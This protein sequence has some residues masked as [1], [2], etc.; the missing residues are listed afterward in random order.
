[1]EVVDVAVGVGLPLDTLLAFS[2]CSSSQSSSNELSNATKTSS[3][4]AAAAAKLAEWRG[5]SF[6]A[7]SFFLGKTSSSSS[8]SSF[9]QVA[10]QIFGLGGE[11]TAATAREICPDRNRRR[12]RRLG[13]RLRLRPRQFFPLYFNVKFHFYSRVKIPF[14]LHT[15]LN[16]GVKLLCTSGRWTRGEKRGLS[17]SLF[18]WLKVLVRL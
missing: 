5:K 17:L 7:S 4:A 18:L 1:V 12:L 16:R 8:S 9:C 14:F 6:F 13:R 3:S 2:S 15:L 11:E 10:C